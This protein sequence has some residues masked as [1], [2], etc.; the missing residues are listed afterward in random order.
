MLIQ[1]LN[2][3]PN[4]IKALF[5]IGQAYG[6]L[7]HYSSAIK[8]FKQALELDPN[9]K[10]IQAELMKIEKAQRQYLVIE[11]KLYAKMFSQ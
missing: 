11:K 6:A 10:K 5:R 4:N 7:N 1:V 3:E 9:D 8:Y 2:L